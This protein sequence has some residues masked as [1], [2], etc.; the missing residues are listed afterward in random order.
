MLD[1]LT[2]AQ[3]MLHED[4]K[5]KNPERHRLTQDSYLHYEATQ[6]CTYCC[7]Y[8]DLNNLFEYDP[9]TDRFYRRKKDETI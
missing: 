9:R 2:L 1:K 3:E 4:D 5:K 8:Y 6:M 7:K